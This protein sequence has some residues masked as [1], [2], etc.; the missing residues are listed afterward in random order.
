[1]LL[2]VFWPMDRTIFDRCPIFP[3]TNV[4]GLTDTKSLGID[5]PKWELARVTRVFG[6]WHSFAT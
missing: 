5:L 3:F 6:M 4:V 1:M 2:G